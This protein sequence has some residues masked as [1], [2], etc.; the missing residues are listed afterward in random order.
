[1]KTLTTLTA[2]GALLTLVTPAFA[3]APPPTTPGDKQ[4]LVQT[5][6]G[7]IA[8]YAN[9]AAAVNRATNPAVRQLGVWQ[10][11]DHDRLNISIFALSAVRG[12][13]LPLTMTAA[14]SSD[15]TTLTAKQGMAFDRAWLQQAIKTNKQDIQDAQKEAAAT[16]DPEI[17]PL[18]RGYLSTE[19]GHLAAARV[20]FLSVLSQPS[21][22]LRRGWTRNEAG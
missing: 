10:M 21:P 18:V 14:E 19:Y 5:A 6:Q 15:L 3:Q 11:G 20:C 9:G 17:Q 8:D 12:V 7:S 1:M 4:F 16:T 13:N 22:F 2:L